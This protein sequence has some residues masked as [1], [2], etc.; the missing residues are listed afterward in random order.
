MRLDIPKTKTQ[1]KKIPKIHI[2][3][4]ILLTQLLWNSK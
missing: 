2:L 4:S 1:F 3:V